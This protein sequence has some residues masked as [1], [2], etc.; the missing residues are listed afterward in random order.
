MKRFLVV[1]VLLASAALAG[2][3]N[4]GALTQKVT[5]AV[6]AGAGG[7]H[8]SLALVYDSTAPDGL[9][10]R[11]WR[12]QGLPQVTRARG[13]RLVAGDPLQTHE[14]LLLPDGTTGRWRA[15]QDDQSAWFLE[16][17]CGT[18]P[19]SVRLEDRNGWRWYFG[20]AEN[21]RVRQGTSVVAWGLSRVVNPSGLA[22]T[23][24]W[25]R[26]GGVLLP[27]AVEWTVGAGTERRHLEFA[28]AKRPAPDRVTTFVAGVEQTLEDRLSSISVFSAGQ[29]VRRYQLTYDA[30]ERRRSLLTQVQE[31]GADGVTALAPLTWSYSPEQPGV[32]SQGSPFPGRVDITTRGGRAADDWRDTRHR[33]HV[34]DFDGDGRA[35]VLLQGVDGTVLATD[36][37][38]WLSSTQAWVNVTAG[39]AGKRRDWSFNHFA[40]LAAD[41]DDDGKADVLRLSFDSTSVATLERSA[42]D[43]TFAGRSLVTPAMSMDDWALGYTSNLLPYRRTPIV[44]DF[45]GD[46]LLDVLL[47][48]NGETEPTRLW[49]GTGRVV[50]MGPETTVPD[51]WSSRHYR[52]TAADFNG[53][54]ISDLLMQGLEP[55]MPQRVLYFDRTG[56]YRFE[57]LP[58]AFAARLTR[59]VVFDANGDGLPDVFLKPI[60][61]GTDGVLALSTGFRFSL[62]PERYA[63]LEDPLV[64]FPGDTDGDGR[65]DLLFMNPS[66]GQ[67]VRAWRSL[68]ATLEPVSMGNNA[69]SWTNVSGGDFD[70]DGRADLLFVGGSTAELWQGTA[71]PPLVMTRAT[72]GTGGRL[73]VEYEYATAHATAF[74]GGGPGRHAVGPT[75]LVIR[76]TSRDGDRASYETSWR[77]SN[78]RLLR[79]ASPGPYRS[80]VVALGFETVRETDAQTTQSVER[81]IDFRAP[82]QGLIRLV[83]TLDATGEVVSLEETVG[84]RNLACVPLTLCDQ[85]LEHPDGL[86]MW[87]PTELKTTT[88]EAGRPRFSRSRSFT[89]DSYGNPREVVERV[90]RPMGV[91]PSTQ[92]RTRYEFN[93]YVN[94]TTP[95]RIIGTP[96]R[97]RVCMDAQC[98][99]VITDVRTTY[100]DA[101][102]GSTGPRALATK[103]EQAAGADWVATTRTYD[104]AGNVLTE[105]GP[106][107]LTTTIRY[108]PL[109]QRERVFLD[110]PATPAR[111]FT[112]D[113]RFNLPIEEQDENGTTVSTTLDALARPTRKRWVGSDGR[114]LRERVLTQS[115]ATATT[116]GFARVCEV[117][118]PGEP[119]DDCR[120]TW[121]DS[122]GRT[123]RSVTWG[124]HG[125]VEVTTTYDAAGRV[126]K[127]SEPHVPNDPETAWTVTE[128]DAAGRTSR[129][130]HPDGTATTQRYNQGSLDGNEVTTESVTGPTGVTTFKAK[131]I[132]GHVVRVTEGTT[133]AGL[134]LVLTTRSVFD[135]RGRLV[136]V[137]TP[138]KT[139]ALTWDD[140]GRKTSIEDPDTGRTEYVYDSG[141]KGRAA[142]G[143]LR[144]LSRPD[145]NGRAERMVTTYEY[146]AEGRVLRE[147]SSDGTVVTSVYDDP[148]VANGL[149][150][151]TRITQVRDGVTLTSAFAFDGLGNRSRVFRS[152]TGPGYAF[153]GG[154]TQQFD[155]FGR[156]WKLT[157]ADSSV[158]TYRYH[159]VSRQPREVDLDGVVIA[160]WPQYTTRGQAAEVQYGNG[161]STTWEYVAA[162]GQLDRTRIVDTETNTSLLDADYRFDAAGNVVEHLDR[163]DGTKSRRFAYDSFQRLAQVREGTCAPGDACR[164]LTYRYD[165]AGSL[166]EKEGVTFTLEP[167]TQR[168]ASNGVESFTWSNA[169]NLLE[170]GLTTYRYDRRNM[171]HSVADNGVVVQRNH[172]DQD[173]RRFVKERVDGQTTT[174]TFFLGRTSELTERRAGTLLRGA[175]LTRFVLGPDG[176][177]LAAVTKDVAQLRAPTFG[178]LQR[179]ELDSAN[180]RTLSGLFRAARAHVALA[181]MSGSVEQ[182]MT[183]LVLLLVTLGAAALLVS[184]RVGRRRWPVVVVM[185]LVAMLTTGCPPQTTPGP[186]LPSGFTSALPPG[187][188]FFHPDHLGSVALVTDAEGAVTAR[189]RYLPYGDLDPSSTQDAATTRRFTGQRYDA[190]T[191]L[192]DFNARTYDPTIGRFLQADTLVP[193][194]GTV[195]GFNRYAF[196]RDNPIRYSDPS[197]H[198]WL[199]TA[200]K[201]VGDWASGLG[202]KGWLLLGAAIVSAVL[203]PFTGGASLYLYIGVATAVGVAEGI[204]AGSPEM[205]VGALATGLSAGFGLP[206]GLSWTP[207]TGWGIAFTAPIPGGEAW[208]LKASVGWSQRGGFEAGVSLG[209]K[210][211]AVSAGYSSKEG[212]YAGFGAGVGSVSLQGRYSTHGGA[213]FGA[214]YDNG[215]LQVDAGF[216]SDRGFYL[217]VRS[218]M[219]VDSGISDF[220]FQ[221]GL[222]AT[223]DSSGPSLS[224]TASHAQFENAE[225]K[226]LTGL[227]LEQANEELN[228]ERFELELL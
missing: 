25:Q 90:E 100:D 187:T 39:S 120:T 68:G 145:P 59:A 133:G 154:E 30:V 191:Q 107:G 176:A 57:P 105:T 122:L 208:G 36:T 139:T 61:A 218:S 193:D 50:T 52:P 125:L 217:G 164:T 38:V 141:P 114:V 73:D 111:T 202:P 89:Y 96:W 126:W 198:S 80:G 225:E 84:L 102:F 48:V 99:T 42:G 144:Q 219:K 160:R 121:M 205:V 74:I 177:V 162:T 20:E 9:V 220:S 28:Y 66:A 172:H 23:V 76:V 34:A 5:I 207:A 213:S 101:P 10:G 173:G 147:S 58:A 117:G 142:W 13:S 49:F 85:N 212:G 171:L 54:G 204:Q 27:S 192:Y 201:K 131:D 72:N 11:G 140:H 104:S 19:C 113:H 78:G 55:S 185:P 53:D 77:Y 155:V 178:G 56:A 161:V 152:A 88:F 47:Q 210:N 158:A 150:K 65:T 197:G 183:L 24:T 109:F 196:S 91:G 143:R 93:D 33:P 60:A 43:G 7:V 112:V 95:V 168:P 221:G 195:L 12:L 216:R 31:F 163:L 32:A 138:G 188:H 45:D 166:L 137:E 41:F 165:A 175:Q 130:V 184:G 211:L 71:T 148:A 15:Q 215:S 206:F 3:S 83:T 127:T 51:F 129:V 81:T 98:A 182:W 180:R 149:G 156:L 136:R 44:G 94:Q 92:V 159:G 17:T 146:D 22:W 226:G 132:D 174:R 228:G 103:V 97:G 69:Q 87:R 181:L 189:L 118:P 67:T 40:L 199:S 18:G 35:D 116:L 190:E 2:V 16:G 123:R 86:A 135:D 179:F 70:G 186:E 82:G 1:P 21:A 224:A 203:A 157:Y 62:R 124:A 37:L 169:G 79:R 167:G 29:L 128:Y 14:G 209:I 223:F 119:L 151:L 222:S 63:G 4:D 110:E 75:P 6:P 64:G 108:D 214:R 115:A 200:W 170:R 134:T 153:S 106:D 227:A 8:P 26:V 46:G 194:S